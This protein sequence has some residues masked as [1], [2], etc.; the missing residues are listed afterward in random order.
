MSW[1]RAKIKHSCKSTLYI[2]EERRIKKLWWVFWV[3]FVCILVFGREKKSVKKLGREQNLAK[4]P[5]FWSKRCLGLFIAPCTF[6]EAVTLQGPLASKYLGFLFLKRYGT[7]KSNGRIKSYG[8]Q[9]FAVH[10]L[11]RHLG[12]RD[13]LAVLTPI[14][15]HEQSL[16]WEFDNLHNGIDFNPFWQPDQN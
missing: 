13:I 5:L 1:N 11:M 4:F 8:S 12:F 15:T 16:E 2:G 9:K 7:W 14:L 6:F 10:W 3:F